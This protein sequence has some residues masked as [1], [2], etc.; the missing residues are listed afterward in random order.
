MPTQPVGVISD[1]EFTRHKGSD[2]T[3]RV[4]STHPPAIERQDL[5]HNGLG[6]YRPES[7]SCGEARTL[8][9]VLRR[10]SGPAVS[11]PILFCGFAW[12]QKV[13]RAALEM[14]RSLR[15][16]IGMTC[17]E[18]RGFLRLSGLRAQPAPI[19]S[20]A[21]CGDNLAV[22]GGRPAPRRSKALRSGVAQR[23]K[24]RPGVTLADACAHSTANVVNA[25][26]SI[27]TPAS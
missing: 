15:G 26:T 19:A 23:Q 2:A 13:Q 5:P 3:H 17:V 16:L 14:P 22:E 18:C 8:A 7:C 24:R 1:H 10:A 27:L 9:R 11:Q 4:H 21:I 12:P 25:R 20:A 6:R